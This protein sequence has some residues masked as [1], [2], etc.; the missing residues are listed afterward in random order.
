MSPDGIKKIFN[1]L[2]PLRA[3]VEVLNLY[4]RFNTIQVEGCLHL[5]DFLE[6]CKVLRTLCLNIQFN[7]IKNLGVELLI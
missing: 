5:K 7:A 3:R 6:G 4:L 1:C 2:K